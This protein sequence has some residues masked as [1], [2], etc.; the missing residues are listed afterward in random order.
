[1]FFE[2]LLKT[3]VREMEAVFAE[4]PDIELDNGVWVFHVHNKLELGF[5]TKTGKSRKIPLEARL[6]EQLNLWHEMRP[7]TQFIFGTARDKPNWH[8]WRTA[9]ETA[10]RAGL[11]PE[12]FWLHKFRATFCTWALRRGVDIRTV[13]GWAGHSKIEVTERYLAPSDGRYAQDKINA[14]FATFA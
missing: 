13:Q 12:D 11:N 8:F 2:F 1:M 4:W 9:K 5:R 6:H 7:R 14:A 3:G 10:T